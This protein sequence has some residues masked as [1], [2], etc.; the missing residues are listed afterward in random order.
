[1]ILAKT[2]LII[3]Y[4]KFKMFHQLHYFGLLYLLVHSKSTYW[5]QS[6]VLDIVDN[7]YQIK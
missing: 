3:V 7:F 4:F 5:V 1:M 6:K 2:F